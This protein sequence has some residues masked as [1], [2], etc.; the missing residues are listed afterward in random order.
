MNKFI[1][2]VILLCLSFKTVYANNNNYGY[3]HC[4]QSHFYYF[5]FKVY[6]IYLCLNDKR[7][8][9]SNRIFQT[10]FSI[11]IHYDM[12]FSKQEL[13]DSSLKEMQR[14]HKI[15]K[16][17]QN[18]YYNTLY[19]MYP[20]IKKGDVIE[21]KYKMGKALLY[22]NKR[23]IGNISGSVFVRRFFDIWLHKDNVHYD[24]KNELLS[25]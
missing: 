8:L 21:A 11:V 6:D 14:Y 12:N 10:D 25:K 16:R 13:A 24:L 1:Y 7:F 20:N 4:N 15:S 2:I 5:L 19:K 23:H 18:Y 9:D 17:Q 3:K 22:Y